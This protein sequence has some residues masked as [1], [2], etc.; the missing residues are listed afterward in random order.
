MSTLT[1]IT[2]QNFGN[3]SQGNQKRKRYKRNPNWKR[4]KS[5]TVCRWHNILEYS[6]DDTRKI[7][8]LIK[9]F[10]KV[11]GYKINAQKYFILL[12]TNNDR[13]ERN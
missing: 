5:N 8:E 7:L 1:T 3:P 11:I 4:S 2:Q 6:E 10:G 9:K 13:S 12:Y